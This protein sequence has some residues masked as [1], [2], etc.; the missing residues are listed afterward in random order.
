MH[1]RT[2]GG[3]FKSCLIDHAGRYG[4]TFQFLRF[5][6]LFFCLFLTLLSVWLLRNLKG[7][8]M[9]SGFGILMREKKGLV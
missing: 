5:L 4:F 7:K 9:K 6:G 8:E 3:L 2:F 1:D